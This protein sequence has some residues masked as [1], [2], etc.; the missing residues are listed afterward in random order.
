MLNKSKGKQKIIKQE[1]LKD[2]FVIKI[3][4]KQ[5]IKA[6]QIIFKINVE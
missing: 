3:S 6:S 2:M 5:K 1:I 4:N